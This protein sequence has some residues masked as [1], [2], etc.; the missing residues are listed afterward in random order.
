MTAVFG[1]M[2]GHRELMLAKKYG[3]FIAAILLPLL[4]TCSLRAQCHFSVPTE[5][6][7]VTYR[8]EPDI[9]SGSLVLHVTLEFR[10][11]SS[12]TETLELPTHWAGETLHAMTN[13][14]VVSKGA[15]LA[16]GPESDARI[17]H[18]P[19][20]H[21]I[22]ISYDLKKDWTGP[23]VNPMQFH[24]VLMPEYLEFTGSNALVRLKMD[25]GAREVANFD[26]SKLP[27]SWTL[28]TSFGAAEPSAL[29]C[30]TYSGP[31]IDVEQGLYAAG[32]YRIHRFPIGGRPAVL[33]VR[34]AWK[35]SDNEAIEQI[36]KTVGIVREFWHQDDFPYFLVT[37]KPYDRDYGSSGRAISFL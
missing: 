10:A 17:L 14:S 35:F 19:S 23:L 7:S 24:P 3:T 34:G 11:G 28:A 30:Q 2:R 1:E 26:W 37:L 9:R 36:R 21:R 6:R 32:D 5:G 27:A 4:G 22:A 20:H 29:R 15:S 8:F 16:V 25:D 12:G 13:L 18:A 31:W 33:A